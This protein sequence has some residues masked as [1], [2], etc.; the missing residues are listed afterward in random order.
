MDSY[1][2]Q[3]RTLSKRAKILDG[4]MNNLY[5]HL[6][7]EWDTI[8]NLGKLLRAGAILDFAYRLDKCVNYLSDTA[9]DF[10]AVERDLQ[11]MC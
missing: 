7:I 11:S 1:A 3:L 6:G 2:K 5:W 8:A 4:K 9:R 10:D